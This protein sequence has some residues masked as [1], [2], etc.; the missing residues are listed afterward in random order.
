MH[1]DLVASA[2]DTFVQ[3]HWCGKVL[4][5]QGQRT[6]PIVVHH[7]WRCQG[8][9]Y[10]YAKWLL[11]EGFGA[12]NWNAERRRTPGAILDVHLAVA[13]RQAELP[14]HE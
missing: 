5:T 10:E 11:A 4:R 12:H 2:H 3:C 9:D 8:L 6:D 13:D 1:R 14:H 7:L